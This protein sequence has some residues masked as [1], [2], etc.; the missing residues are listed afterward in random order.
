MSPAAQAILDRARE[1]SAEANR[2]IL[3]IPPAAAEPV[4][5]AAPERVAL[6]GDEVLTAADLAL[7]EGEPHFRREAT[8][9]GLVAQRRA[10][11][12][13]RPP[14]PAPVRRQLAAA[15]QRRAPK[16][17]KP[18]TRD[19]L[20]RWASMLTT[21]IGDGVG[22]HLRLIRSDHREL[23]ELVE[24]LAGRVAELEGRVTELENRNDR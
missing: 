3:G 21:T 14:E 17:A 9:R 5:H 11:A 15:V 24:A 16:A 23:A 12:S 7:L 2:A 13:R 19:T 10:E 4:T 20:S 18:V 1:V 22:K 6:P 8:R